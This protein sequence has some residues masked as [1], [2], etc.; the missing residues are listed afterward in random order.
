MRRRLDVRRVV[1][2]DLFLG[3][4][5]VRGSCWLFKRGV[6]SVTLSG[7]S[8][9]SSL[10]CSVVPEV[11]PR[12]ARTE[13]RMRTEPVIPMA[14]TMFSVR[15]ILSVCPAVMVTINAS[16]TIAAFPDVI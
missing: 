4:H 6:S 2:T 11:N 5:F 12:E 15:K 16:T 3:L 14:F 9:R 1:R 10:S 13:W 8:S 7:A